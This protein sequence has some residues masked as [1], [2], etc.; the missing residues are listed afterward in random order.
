MR[1]T[2]ELDEASLRKIQEVTGEKKKSPAVQKALQ[3]FL[4]DQSRRAFVQQVR[5]G[6]IDFPM[7]NDQLEELLEDDPDRHV[8]VD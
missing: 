1:I 7:T 2:V 5:E 3:A 8:G 6:R 4:K